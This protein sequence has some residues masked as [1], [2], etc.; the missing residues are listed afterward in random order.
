MG[1]HFGAIGL[2][3]DR[4]SLPEAFRRMLTTA[5]LVGTAPMGDV[6]VYAYEDGS[7]SRATMTIVGEALTCFTPSFRP[8]T[9]LRV[10]AGSL[11]ASD[12]DYE[13]PLLAELLEDGEDVYPLAVAI[14]DLAATERAIPIG[15]TVTLEVAA[16]AEQMEVFT[17]ETAYR[18]GGTM[19]AVRS[20]IPS[21]L[22]AIGHEPSEPIMPTPRILMSGEVSASRMLRHEV[23]GVPFCHATVGS[24]GADYEVL[25]DHADLEH[26]GLEAGPPVGSILSGTY[27]LSGR[28]VGGEEKTTA[29]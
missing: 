9:R 28:V 8:G 26:L 10:R 13:R 17:D 21:G 3:S 20:V 23:F 22:F 16:L 25:I 7:G 1:S 11:G 4:D 27:W 14:E 12:C 5:S 2:P 19:M 29:H 15:E 24:Y 18:A 6:R